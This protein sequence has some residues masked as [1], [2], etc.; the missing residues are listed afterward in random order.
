MVRPRAGRRVLPPRRGRD[1]PAGRLHPHLRRVRARLG[2][3]AGG[4]RGHPRLRHHAADGVPGQDRPP[5]PA[6]PAGPAGH[7]G[8]VGGHGG[9]ARLPGA[10]PAG[11]GGR[12]GLAGRAAA[13]GRAPRRRRRRPGAP[14]R[15]A[16]GPAGGGVLALHRPPRA[17]GDLPD[18][19]A[20]AE[21]AADRGA[22]LDQGGRGVR[23]QLPLPGHGG[24]GRGGHPPGPRP[25]AER[26]AGPPQH[27]A[28]R[29]RLPDDHQLD[30]RP[31]LAHLPGPAD[32]RPGAAGGVRPR[33]RRRRRRAG[34]PV[35]HHAAGHRRRPGRRGPADGRPQ[36]L[37]PGQHPGRPG[38]Q[39]GPQLRPH[40]PLRPGRGGGRLR[41]RHPA[42]QPAPPGP[43]V[44]LDGPA[45]VRAG[46]RGGRGPV[47]GQ[48]RGGRAGPAG[49]ARPDPH[50]VRG[51]RRGRLRAVRGPAVALPGPAGMGGAQRHP[52]PPL[53]GP[54]GGVMGGRP[55]VVGAGRGR[56]R[57]GRGRVRGRPR[58][59]RAGRRAGTTGAR[60]CSCW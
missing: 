3:V 26:A 11:A 22:A 10:V 30:G 58:V 53:P 47:G 21:H 27:R 14:A 45:P 13:P 50:R 7:P 2:A 12:A 52:A 5:G 37:E 60:T 31:Q 54:G 20:V 51:L 1:R 28:G 18:H 48:L 36:R 16:A 49:R 29:G 43:G 55:L 44:A 59:G 40:P 38:G 25:Q 15:P 42:Q 6:A 24:H 35:G 33:L 8:R 39:P 41:R 46:H 19:L 17:G 34:R 32:L 56:P 4:V 23:G 57:A 9:R